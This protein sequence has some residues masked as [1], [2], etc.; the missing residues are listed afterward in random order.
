MSKISVA[1][2]TYNGEQFILAQL[3]S[4]LDQVRKP[5][6]VV[7]CDDGSQDAT[8]RIIQDFIRINQL[9]SWTLIQNPANL[10]FVKNF[11]K[12]MAETTGDIVFLC[13]QDDI[14]CEDKI[15]EMVQIMDNNPQILALASGYSLLDENGIVRASENKKLYYPNV[16]RDDQPFVSRVKLGR[17]L[18]SNMAQGCTCAY[19]RRVIDD[20]CNATECVRMPH[21]WALNMMAYQEKGLFFVDREFVRY[22]IHG[23]N[24]TGLVDKEMVVR[25]RI[26]R[27]EDYEMCMKDAMHLPIS[28]KTKEEIKRIVDFSNIRLQWLRHKCVFT[29]MRGLFLFFPTIVRYFFWQYMKDF[30]LVLLGKVPTQ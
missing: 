25:C 22:R 6:E 4:L 10:G 24:T 7:I 11:R 1:M 2:T 18:H 16:D 13:D 21:D 9:S 8:I 27:V 15:S 26:P 23:R 20:Y 28:T 3:Q 30:A 14:W 12:A 17:I 5:D 19:R 29:W